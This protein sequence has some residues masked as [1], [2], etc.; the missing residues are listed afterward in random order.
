MF[1]WFGVESGDAMR[2]RCPGGPPAAPLAA[3]LAFLTIAA[4]TPGPSDASGSDQVIAYLAH[5]SAG[6]ANRCEWRILDPVSRN[7][8][9][10][11]SY[12]HEVRGFDWDSTLSYVEY[13]ESGELYRVEWE[14]DAQPWPTIQLPPVDDVLDCWLNLDENRWQA[15]SAGRIGARDGSG[16][17]LC[18]S[19]LW[20]SDRDGESWRIARAET[21]DCGACLYCEELKTLNPGPIRRGCPLG[22]SQLQARMASDYL[23]AE[24]IPIAPPRGESAVPYDWYFL[25]SRSD[26]A[27]G[28]ALRIRQHPPNPE[29]TPFAPFYLLDRRRGT[30]RMLETPGLDRD[31]NASGLGYFERDGFLLVL[32]VDVKDWRRG[33]RNYVFDLDSGDQIFH[34]P[35]CE[36]VTVVWVKRPRPARVDSAGLRRLRERFR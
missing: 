27:R 4:C 6:N 15:L 9:L 11:R 29:K 1:R 8:E 3:I 24:M 13:L 32:S 2:R 19:E 28:L 36:S 18:R 5:V 21:T 17:V 26:P 25:P 31:D 16:H 34:P 20:Q 23:G 12:Q 22:L 10:F 30:Q 14:N 35:R 33:T 7:D